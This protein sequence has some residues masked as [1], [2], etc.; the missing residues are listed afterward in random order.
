MKAIAELDCTNPY[1]ENGKLKNAKARFSQ[2]VT[3]NIV[4]G[5]NTKVSEIKREGHDEDNEKYDIELVFFCNNQ[6]NAH[7]SDKPVKIPKS[8][9][10]YMEVDPLTCEPV[11]GPVPDDLIM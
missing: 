11:R 6:W 3:Q 7:A 10:P 1:D 8:W 4:L 2:A 5:T 9:E